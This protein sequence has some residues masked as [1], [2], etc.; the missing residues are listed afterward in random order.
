[1]TITLMILTIMAMTMMM[2]MMVIQR[3]MIRMLIFDDDYD[4]FAAG[5]DDL[6]AEDAGYNFD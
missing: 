5:D 1:M 4:E 2:M 6:F 3:M